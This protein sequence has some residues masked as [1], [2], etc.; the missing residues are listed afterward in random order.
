MHTHQRTWYKHACKHIICIH[1]LNVHT[2]GEMH[3]M[4]DSTLTHSDTHAHTYTHTHTHTCI[5]IHRI[6][7]NPHILFHYILVLKVKTASKKVCKLWSLI[8]QEVPSRKWPSGSQHDPD[9]HDL[10]FCAVWVL[11]SSLS[12]CCI[13][14]S[15]WLWNGLN[16]CALLVPWMKD[17]QCI[18]ISLPLLARVTVTISPFKVDHQWLPFWMPFPSLT[19]PAPLLHDVTFLSGKSDQCWQS[20]FSLTQMQILHMLM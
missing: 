6:K 7:K 1:C 3:K 9:V 2:D 4:H 14:S 12:Q 17:R 8:D 5:I 18:Y 11:G 10:A 13:V 15:S 20:T 19:L 16:T